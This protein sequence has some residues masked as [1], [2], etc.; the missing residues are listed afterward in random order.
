MKHLILLIALF[1]SYSQ[2]QVYTWI[3][4]DGVKVY[5]DEPPKHATKAQLPHIQTMPSKQPA[6]LLDK[7]E[8]Q[9]TQT[10]NPSEFTGYTRLYIVSPKEDEMITADKAGHTSVQLHIDP[11]LQPSHEVILYLDGRPVAQG[12][13]LYFELNN[14]FRGSHLIQAKIKHQGKLLISSPKR[15]I[16]VQRPSILN[17]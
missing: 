14:I 1:S 13:Q 10:S 15:R 16:H 7:T 3:N 4:K 8:T 5:G 17:R 2:A 6:K 12:G 11:A 9:K